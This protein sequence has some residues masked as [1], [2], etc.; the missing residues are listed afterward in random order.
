MQRVLVMAA[1]SG[2]RLLLKTPTDATI[3]IQTAQPANSDFS[4]IG[5]MQST[6]VDWSASEI[7][8]TTQ[9]SDENRELLDGRGIKSL[10]FAA[11]GQLQDSQIAKD[12]EANFLTQRL[13]WFQVE[14]EDNTNRRYTVKFKLTSYSFS[15]NHDGSVDFNLTLM[16]SGAIS[17][18]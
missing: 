17:I 16:S 3:A 12:L 9:S 1:L 4:T 13:R 15:G 10:N 11:S 8:V 18:A 2:F 7:D 6:N 5:G 14:Q